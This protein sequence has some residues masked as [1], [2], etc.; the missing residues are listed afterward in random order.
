M[1]GLW[2][3]DLA[4]RLSVDGLPAQINHQGQSYCKQDGINLYRHI[5][6]ICTIQ[7]ACNGGN[8]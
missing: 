8:D 3:V 2:K 1:P 7:R 6:I 4:P 5:Q